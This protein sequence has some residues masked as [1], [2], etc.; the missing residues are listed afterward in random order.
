[1]PTKGKMTPTCAMCQQ[2]GMSV[3]LCEKH[4]ALPE[5]IEA[6]RNL[7][8]ACRAYKV[9]ETFTQGMTRVLARIDGDSNTEPQHVHSRAGN[10]LQCSG[11]GARIDGEG[12]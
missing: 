7:M 12:A 5:L 4:A 10:S 2:V 11:C 1:M 8:A 9:P 6:A 3:R